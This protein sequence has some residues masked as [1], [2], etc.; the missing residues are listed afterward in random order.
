MKWM[1]AGGGGVTLVILALGVALAPLGR[2]ADAVLAWCDDRFDRRRAASRNQRDGWLA[3]LLL[4]PALALL[5]VFSLLPLGYTAY[6]S[7]YAMRMGQG[8]FVGFANY[9][10]ALTN[11]EFW[12]SLLVTVYYAA[13]TIPATMALSFVLASML[14]RMVRGRGLF[15]TLYFLPYVTSVVAAAT[16]W[17]ALLNP[18]FGPVNAFLSSLG[19][20]GPA[21]LLEPRGVLSLLTGGLVPAS[22]GPSL[23]LCCI[24]I[25]EM[26]HSFG[27]M[28]IIFLA[29]LTAIPRELEDAARIDGAGWTQTHWHVTLPLLSP[30]ILFL[31]VVSVVRAFQSFSSFYALAGFKGRGPANS[32]QNLVVYLY[33]SFYE[34]GEWGY[35]AAVATL[36]SIA[37]VMLTLLQWRFLGRRTHHA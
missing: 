3:F 1:L 17:R 7:L 2:W 12:Q 32:T 36:L 33:T 21:W 10:H 37:I 34:Y 5:G 4:F 6:A 15:R 11:P 19:A 35:G 26:W 27:F 16:V 20:P 29:G 23:S 31:A 24:M 30:T 28:V 8:P 14:F 18:N 22:V 9:V 25:F 13:G